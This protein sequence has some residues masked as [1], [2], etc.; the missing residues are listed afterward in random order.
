MESYHKRKKLLEEKYGKPIDLKPYNDDVGIADNKQQKSV[1]QV[2]DI[3][4]GRIEK[5]L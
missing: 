5:S 4:D 2:Q 3:S 1:K